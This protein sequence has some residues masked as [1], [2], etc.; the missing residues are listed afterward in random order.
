[1]FMLTDWMAA[2]MIALGWIQP[3]NAANVPNLHDNLIKPLRGKAW[4]KDRDL[5]RAV[6][7][8]PD[9]HRLQ[10]G[11]D[12]CRRLASRSCSRGPT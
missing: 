10:L 7:G 12:R 6:A 11:G 3:L 1:M 9:R 4:D 8:G 2:R 5:L